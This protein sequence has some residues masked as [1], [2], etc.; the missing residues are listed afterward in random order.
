MKNWISRLFG[1]GNDKEAADDAANAAMAELARVRVPEGEPKPVPSAEVMRT[2][3]LHHASDVNALF[4]RWLIGQHEQTPLPSSNF[5]KQVLDALEALVKSELGGANLVPRVPAVIPQLLRSMRDETTSALDLAKQI[6][7]D[8]VLVAEVIHEANSPFYHP[9]KPIHNIE[10]AVMVLGQNGLRLVIARVAFRPIINMQ[11]GRFAQMV[12]PKIWA[13]SEKCADA[14]KILAGPMRAD[15]FIAFLAGLIQNVGMIVAFRVIDR[16]YQGKLLP[17]SD[18]FCY[19]FFRL[20]RML[21]SRIAQ[22]W[23]FPPQVIAGLQNLA[24]GEWANH[25]MEEVLFVSDQMGKL[26]LLVD[27]RIL[28]EDEHFTTNGMS[29]EALEYFHKMRF[30]ATAA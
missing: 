19:A 16:G 26:R 17:D 28:Q 1:L 22:A 10:N 20:S 3:R 5:E 15:P 9:A 21:S 24:T 12:A 6:S 29:P 11:A 30:L 7:H 25:A 8:I 27:Q 4:Y 13:Q 14:C 18:H 2:L 23:D